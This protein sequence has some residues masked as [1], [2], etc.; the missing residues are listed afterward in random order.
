MNDEQNQPAE[1]EERKG[2]S[3]LRVLG[4]T[5][6]VIVVAVVLLAGTC[7]LVATSKL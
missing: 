3:F 2:P 5:V 1:G 7:V 4:I 6:V